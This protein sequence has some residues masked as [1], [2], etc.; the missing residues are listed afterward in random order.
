MNYSIGEVANKLGVSSSTLR[1]YDRE[2]LLPKLNRSGG[3]T[4]VFTALE[5]NTLKIIECLKSAGL[6]IKDI[7]QYM[8]WHEE[9]DSTLQK[10]RDLFYERMEVVKD[11]IKI[12]ENTMSIIKY[13]CWYYDKAVEANS[14]EDMSKISPSEMPDEIKEILKTFL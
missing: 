1:F 6:S 10:R 11:Q 5:I 13:K 4:R 3:G 12:L 9:G 8:N 14:E 2:G 7:K